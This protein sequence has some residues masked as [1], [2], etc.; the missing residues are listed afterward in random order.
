MKEGGRHLSIHLRDHTPGYMVRITT[1]SDDVMKSN[2]PAPCHYE[3]KF[4]LPVKP[5]TVGNVGNARLDQSWIDS[6]S[7]NGN[8]TVDVCAITQ[9]AGMHF[10]ALRGA[11]LPQC[12]DFPLGAGFYPT[13]LRADY[14]K[15]RE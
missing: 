2:L 8:G 1:K 14:H 6:P 9:I 11:K 13:D 4:S 5:T 7:H 12:E 10:I 15:H 3:S